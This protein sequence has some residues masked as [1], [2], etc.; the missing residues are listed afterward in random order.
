[1]YSQFYR[2]QILSWSLVILRTRTRKDVVLNLYWKTKQ[3]MGRNDG[4]NDSSIGCRIWSPSF[5]SIQCLWKKNT[6]RHLSIQRQ[7]QKHRIALPHNIICQSAQHLWI[8]RTL[9]QIFG[10]RFIWSSFIRWFTQLRNT[11]CNTDIGG[12]KTITK[13]RLQCLTRMSATT[14]RVLGGNKAALQTNLSEQTNA[15]KS[16]SAIRRQ[17]RLRCW[18]ENRMEVVQ[19]AGILAAFFFFVVL[20]MAEFFVEKIGLHGGGILQSLTKG[21]E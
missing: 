4:I 8:Y 18:S 14:R 17:R 3:K 1:M 11:F 5:S 21:S 7:W 19:R 9:Y 12:H 2:S 20:I 10:R 6:V 15:S 16:E 13:R